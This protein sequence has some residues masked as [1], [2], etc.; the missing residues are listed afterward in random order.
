MFPNAF[1]FSRLAQ[2]KSV[3]AIGVIVVA[4]TSISKEFC[5]THLQRF[6]WLAIAIVA[7]SCCCFRVAIAVV[8][9]YCCL[10][11]HFGS[12]G[13]MKTFSQAKKKPNQNE[14]SQANG[15]PANHVRHFLQSIKPHT[16][17]SGNVWVSDCVCVSVCVCMEVAISIAC[18]VH[19]LINA[20]K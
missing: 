17:R 19:R 10:A 20:M 7:C 2:F 8:V 3:A 11:M 13:S 4:V 16:A 5:L 12:V 15:Q 6:G 18:S 1:C 14:P 9:V